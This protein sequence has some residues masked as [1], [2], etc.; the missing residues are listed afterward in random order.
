MKDDISG[1]PIFVEMNPRF[2]GG[3]YF[4]TLAGV[5]F[6]KLMFDVIDSNKIEVPEPKE[7]TVLR[8]YNEIVI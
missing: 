3:T 8:Y 4:T 7:I 5:N 2:G 1:H 6:M